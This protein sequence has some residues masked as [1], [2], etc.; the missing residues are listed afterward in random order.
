MLIA[1]R[2]RPALNIWPG[3]VDAL[4]ALLMVVIFVL[5]LFSLGQFLLNDALIGRDEALSR[6]RGQLNNLTTLLALTREEKQSLEQ[7]LEGV[8]GELQ[9][10]QA[11]RDDLQ[12]RLAELTL[13]AHD[14]ELALAALKLELNSSRD[15][16]AEQQEPEKHG[17]GQS[18]ELQ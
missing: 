17:E 7:R 3:F 10:T 2:R 13:K 18:R 6:L 8:A 4:A 11:T 1:S 16:L 9:I 15:Q 5:L 14:V 12:A